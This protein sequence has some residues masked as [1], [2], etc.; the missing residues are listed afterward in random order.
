MDIRDE[1]ALQIIKNVYGDS[2]KLRSGA[3]ALRYRLHQKSVLLTLINDVTVFCVA[4]DHAT[5][6]HKHSAKVLG[7]ISHSILDE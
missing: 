7:V 1:C 6:K 4:V 3:N 5:N 2:I